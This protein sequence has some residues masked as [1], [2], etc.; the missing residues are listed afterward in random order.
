MKYLV[1]FAAATLLL[2]FVGVGLLFAYPRPADTTDF[3]IFAVDGAGLDHCSAAVF[4]ALDGDGLDAD[5]IPKAYT[6]GCGWTRWPG[7]VLGA[8][9]EPLARDAQDLRGLWVAEDAQG[10]Y[11]ER[12]EQCG[13]RV[14]VT[15][16]GIIHDFR[17]DGTLANG[18][19]D[20]RPQGCM[21]IAAAIAWRGDTLS[22]RPLGLP[23]EIV[24]RR[25]DDAGRLHWIYP[26]RGETVMER[27]CTVPDA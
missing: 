9:R 11:V 26:G 6:P 3:A 24:T 8:C 16:S 15:S 19:R 18:A 5:A 27:V 10:T 21:N 7:P 13:D 2:V 12:I 17:T 22:F 1:G 23:L 14:V 4:P 20:V 25:L